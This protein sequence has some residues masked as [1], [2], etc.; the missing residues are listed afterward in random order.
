MMIA[1]LLTA[2]LFLAQPAAP[3]PAPAA[4]APAQP[5]P[6]AK[7][8]QPPPSARLEAALVD[9]KGKPTTAFTAKLGP[10]GSIRQATDGQVLFWTINVPGET[11]CGPDPAGAL[12]CQRQ[13]GGDCVVAVAF[14]ADG[15]MSVWRT[16]GF[17]AACEKA[18]DQLKPAG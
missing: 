11:V 5:A 8:T 17:P 2:L 14:K 6:A 12:I 13:G 10:A 9:L 16:T 4:A 1:P 7:A 15:L 18:A 3:A